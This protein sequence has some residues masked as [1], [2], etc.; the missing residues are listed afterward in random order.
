MVGVRHG[1][2]KGG[3]SLPLRSWNE[4]GFWPSWPH[5]DAAQGATGTVASSLQGRKEHSA[6]QNAFPRELALVSKWQEF[7]KRDEGHTSQLRQTPVLPSMMPLPLSM[8]RFQP[9]TNP[10]LADVL[11]SP[12]HGHSGVQQG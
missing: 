11:P 1:V 10:L 2:P 7:L 3:S 12:C 8:W 4:S 6:G 5:S 9:A